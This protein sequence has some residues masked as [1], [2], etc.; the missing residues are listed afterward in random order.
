MVLDPPVC[1]MTPGVVPFPSVSLRA[2]DGLLKLTPASKTKVFSN[3]S[4]AKVCDPV[5]RALRVLAVHVDSPVAVYVDFARTLPE[6]DA[7]S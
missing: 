6:T 1:T 4:P 5:G 3:L 7:K 2:A